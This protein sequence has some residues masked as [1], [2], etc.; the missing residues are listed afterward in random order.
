MP[1]LQTVSQPAAGSPTAALLDAVEKKLG[2]VPN[3]LRTMANS[4]AVLEAYVGFSNTLTKGSLSTRLREQIALAVGEANNCQYCLAAHTALGSMAG[5][6]AEEID[7]SRRG[8]SADPKTAAALAFARTLVR[9][10]GNV[11]DFDVQGLRSAG[12]DDVAIAEVVASVALNLFTNYFNHVAETEIDFPAA[13][14][15]NAQPAGAS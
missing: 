6:K 1:R 2:K 4:P 15:C 10:R 3:M 9:Q 11:N 7:A 12:F 13:A 8:E 14:P 5:L